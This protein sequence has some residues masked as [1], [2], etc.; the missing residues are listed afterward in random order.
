MEYPSDCGDRFHQYADQATQSYAQCVQ[1]LQE[2]VA[3]RQ[4]QHDS[5]SKKRGHRIKPLVQALAPL[6]NSCPESAV[7]FVLASTAPRPGRCSARRLCPRC[8]FGKTD[9]GAVRQVASNAA[10]SSQVAVSAGN[11][12]QSAAPH[13]KQLQHSSKEIGGILKLTLLRSQRTNLLALNAAIE[14]PSG[15]SG[16]RG[17]AVVA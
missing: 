11:M 13:K 16:P 8:G 3:G 17:F 14:G 9:E 7:S 4:P 6:R 12:G 15:L 5:A 2:E 10:E 1:K